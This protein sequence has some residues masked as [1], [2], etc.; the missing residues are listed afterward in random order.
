MSQR[1]NK[2][3]RV[4]PNTDRK[5]VFVHNRFVGPLPQRTV[6]FDVVA[7]PFQVNCII[8]LYECVDPLSEQF[9]KKYVGQTRDPIE[10]RHNGHLHGRTK[11]GKAF[12]A[13]PSGF[14]R[15]IIEERCFETVA[16]TK[17]EKAKLLVVAQEWMNEREIHWI[18]KH[19][20]FS[21]TKG[22]NRDRGGQKGRNQKF[23]EA[24]LLDQEREWALRWKALR[25]FKAKHGHL[26]VPKR[27]RF[28]ANHPNATLC[29]YRLGKAVSNIRSG[30]ITSS[31]AEKQRLDAMG[32]VWRIRTFI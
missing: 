23:F 15:T 26:L 21:N 24:R 9:R 31:D 32:F 7:A 27:Y 19:G 20:S 13:N 3:A 28:P 18:A 11:F 14:S 22:F 2:R 17:A 29:G 10:V 12:K 25:A 30:T 5:V 4:D 16:S 6:G 1:P 8:Y